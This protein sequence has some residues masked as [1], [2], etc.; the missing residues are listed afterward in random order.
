[1]KWLI[2]SSFLV[3]WAR[4]GVRCEET[5]LSEAQVKRPIEVKCLAGTE[6][7]SN[8][9]QCRCLPF[10][11]AL[12][13][14]LEPCDT[15]PSAEPI[16]CKPNTVFHR[17]CNSCLCL[18][19]GD[20]KCSTNTCQRSDIP[21]KSDLLPG[22][23]CSPGSKWTSQCNECT[24][25]SEG[26]PTCTEMKCSGQETE[27]VFS[28]APESVWKNDCNT[29][30]CTDGRAVCTKIG[31]SV[32]PALDFNVDSK[33]YEEI[34]EPAPNTSLTRKTRASPQEP[35]KACQP[36]QEF[37]MDCNKCLCDNEG[38]DFSCTR[39]DCNALNNNNNGGARRKRD[40]TVEVAA[41][42]TAGS[43]FQ[44]ECN[45]CRCGADGL[46]ATCTAHDCDQV[47]VEQGVDASDADP[48]FRCNPG[49]QFKRECNDCTCSA[50]GKSVFCTLRLCSIYQP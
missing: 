48:N 46:R 12:C 33:D 42:C 19:N 24:C 5:A 11:I 29:C 36:G 38:Q 16:T 18:A 2:L 30:W 8:C 47:K 21:K 40:T 32:I 20:V 41:N 35:P 4:F 9:H 26:Y 14:K 6:W 7:E 15:S 25:S 39:I 34:V 31:C 23:E 37:R 44:K 22:K 17:D 45:V 27:T 28:C 3:C 10:G 43:V 13:H 49:E 50:D 1:M